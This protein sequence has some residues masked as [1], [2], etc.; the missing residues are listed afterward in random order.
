MRNPPAE[1]SP[2]VGDGAL[3]SLSSTRPTAAPDFLRRPVEQRCD[4]KTERENRTDS[5][6]RQRRSDNS[7]TDMPAAPPISLPTYAPNSLPMLLA[8][9]SG[10]IRYTNTP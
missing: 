8:S 3:E 6:N 9:R 1:A 4:T 7:C 2:V 5:G 10:R